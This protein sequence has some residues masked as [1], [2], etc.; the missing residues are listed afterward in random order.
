MDNIVANPLGPGPEAAT[1]ERVGEIRAQLRKLEVRDWWL[2]SLAIVV[3]LLLTGAVVSLSF[4]GLT[5]VEDPFFQYSL[6]RA[7]RGL[8]G[9]VLIFN[10]YSIYQ[11]VLLKR[12]RRQFSE[13]LDAVGELRMH[14]EKLRLLATVDALTGLA[15][16]RAGE[17]RLSAE[18]SRSERHGYPITL[19]AFDL[20]GFKEINDQ[21]GHAAG[22]LVLREFA[23]KL[24][25][26]LR[27]SDLAVRLG[28]D[29]FLA[30]L[31]EC[32]TDQA[33]NLLNRLR[34]IEV[35]FQG[36]QIPVEFSAGSVGFEP[37]DTPAEFLE[38]ADRLLYA[39]KRAR[40]GRRSDVR[41]LTSNLA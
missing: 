27:A 14:A 15:N 37:G 22:D 8:V 29:E 36:K 26:T 31:P 24:A 16:R 7:V 41:D 35:N 21:H 10:S 39:D 25:N 19:V 5:A 20:N 13:Q 34:P 40:K 17:D 2:W 33:S 4:P 23:Q 3:M 30:I 9:L 38:R 6:N 28:G 12:L 1:E 18:L 11:Q 32:K